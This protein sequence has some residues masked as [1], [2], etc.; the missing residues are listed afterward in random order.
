MRPW[1]L[2]GTKLDA[3]SDREQALVHLEAAAAAHGVQW[4]AISAVTGEGI[5]RLL[6]VLFDLVAGA[7]EWP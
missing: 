6:E 5:D 3:L 7:R 2:V 1:V 4:R